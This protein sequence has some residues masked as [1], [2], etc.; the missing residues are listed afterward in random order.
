MLPIIPCTY[1]A[2]GSM[3]S[4]TKPWRSWEPYYSSSGLKTT[5]PVRLFMLPETSIVSI[6]P[7]QPRKSGH[8]SPDLSLCDDYYFSQYHYHQGPTHCTLWL[9]TPHCTNSTPRATTLTP[10]HRK[11]CQT[12]DMDPQSLCLQCFQHMPTPTF[13]DH[14]WKAHGYHLPS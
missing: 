13:A 8:H 12:R 10:H 3:E 5:K 2:M 6:C 14:D 1:K 11:L 9:L 7:R 4:Q